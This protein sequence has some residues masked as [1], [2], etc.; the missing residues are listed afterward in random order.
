MYIGG[1]IRLL[2]GITEPY[3]TKRNACEKGG[4]E[5]TYVGVRMLNR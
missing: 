1:W 5:W 3:E 4:L 2:T